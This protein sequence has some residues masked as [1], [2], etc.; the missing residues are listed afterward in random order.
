MC[1]VGRMV[2]KAY[3]RQ[4]DLDS[5][6]KDSRIGSLGEGGAAAGGEA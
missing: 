6:H 3:A 1:C 5:N 4:E 2:K